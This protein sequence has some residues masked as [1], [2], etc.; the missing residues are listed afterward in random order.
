M[1]L[2]VPT[3]IALALCAGC[4]RQE[5]D[6]EQAR[7]AR[8]LLAEWTLLAE[9]RP[10]LPDTYVRQMREEARRELAAVVASADKAGNPASRA[11][12]AVAGAQGDPPPAVLHQRRRAAQAIERS[13]EAR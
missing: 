6:L 4:S 9:L 11:I 12:A 1:R 10:R 13:L 3:T 5:S 2:L 8:S 7:T